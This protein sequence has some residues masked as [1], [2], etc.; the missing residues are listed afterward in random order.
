MWV[1]LYNALYKDLISLASIAG[2]DESSLQKYFYPIGDTTSKSILLNLCSSLQNSGMMHN[3]IKFNDSNHSYRNIIQDALF[4]YDAKKASCF[5]SDWQSIYQA[6]IDRGISDNGMKKKKETNWEKYCRGIYDGLQFLACENGGKIIRDLV[7]VTTL[8]EKELFKVIEISKRIHGLGFSL[9][10]DWLK[11]CG[12]T[13]LAKPDV[14]I[15]SVIQALN[16]KKKLKD[17]DVIELMYSWADAV[18]ESGADNTVTAYKIDKI[19]WL[20]CTSEF[21]L[22]DGIKA[23]RDAIIRKIKTLNT[24]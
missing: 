21:Y 3:S 15:Y 18:K 20:L 7:A 24:R 9:T 5:Y 6:V 23:G 1:E 11:E 8:T 17:R 14:H 2:V 4:D 12:C 19:I 16:P 22:D 13:W 10:C